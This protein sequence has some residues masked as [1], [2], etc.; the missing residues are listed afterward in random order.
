MHLTVRDLDRQVEYYERRIGLRVRSRD[1]AV[2]LGAGGEALLALWENPRGT[3][4]RRATGLFHFAIL[5]P[6]R[7][8]LA[9]TLAHLIRTETPIAGAADHDVSEALYLSDPEGNGIE[10][11][12][13]RPREEW[14]REGGGYRMGVE[15]LDGAGLLAEARDAPDR[16]GVLPPETRIG[17]IHLHVRA[18]DEARQFYAGALGFQETA[19]MGTS[20]LFVSAGG[21]HHHVGLNTWNGVG[22]P[23][24]PAGSQGLRR[25]EIVLPDE[26]E[27]ERVASRLRDAGIATERGDEGLET[28]DPSGNRIVLRRGPGS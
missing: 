20:A 7:P 13:D 24:P 4:P 23:A 22:A 17:H 21:Y 3:R 11:Y 9:R 16:G 27:V 2:Q 19:R 1:G 26:A 18:I 25:Y 28:A 12:R 8:C 6:S 14:P 5:L 10:I 15:P